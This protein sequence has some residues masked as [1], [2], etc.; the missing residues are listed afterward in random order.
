M[1]EHDDPHLGKAEERL[2]GAESE[3]VNHRYNNAA[4]RCSHAC[5]QAAIAALDEAGTRSPGSQSEPAT[6]FPCSRSCLPCSAHEGFYLPL[7]GRIAIRGIGILL[8]MVLAFV[9]MHLP[10]SLP[11]AYAAGP[12]RFV[13][14]FAAFHDS[15]PATVGDCA[16]DERHNPADGDALQYTTTGMLVW[17]KAD[18]LTAFTDGTRSWIA[19]PHG[20]QERLNGQRFSWEANPDGLPLADG[21]AARGHVT[22]IG[23]S[24]MLGAAGALR[25][26]LGDVDV[27]AAVSRQASA[28]I[29]ILA[30]RRAAGT[31]GPT[32]VIHLGTNGTFTAGQ[33]DQI[34]RMLAGERR[35]VIVNDRAD[36]AWTGPNN[37]MLAADVPRYPKRALGG[38]VRRQRRPVRPLLGRRHPPASRRGGA[39]RPPH[40]RHGGRAVG[41]DR[42]GL[43]RQTAVET[44]ARRFGLRAPQTRRSGASLSRR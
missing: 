5:F 30:A 18:N 20:I 40:R 7:D 28:G 37:A 25:Q 11:A 35:V 2:E 1:L 38:L 24:V 3:F 36:R 8:G 42:A 44:R 19:G 4:D 6:T 14:G 43:A 32:I 17:R 41:P 26:M 22:A 12:C 27:D 23:D 39:V 9:A 10:V 13:L 15:I 34:M 29:A 33:L 21:P 31:L 16:D